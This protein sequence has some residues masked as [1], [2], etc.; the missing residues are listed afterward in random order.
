MHPYR[1]SNDEES[2]IV[3]RQLLAAGLWLLALGKVQSQRPFQLQWLLSNNNS[4][5]TEL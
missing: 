4:G 3:A 1:R 5:A 2:F